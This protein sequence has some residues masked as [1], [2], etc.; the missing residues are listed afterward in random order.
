MVRYFLILS[1]FS[2][3]LWSQSDCTLCRSRFILRT[4]F[5]HFTS[6][7]LHYSQAWIAEGIP[8]YQPKSK[9]NFIAR[10]LVEIIENALNEIYLIHCL[11]QKAHSLQNHWPNSWQSDVEGS[12]YD[13][14]TICLQALQLILILLLPP[15]SLV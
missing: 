3:I 8:K 1:R 9:I 12:P 5:S 4:T 15:S 7:T 2:A 13:D 14:Q 6:V 10:D 11:V